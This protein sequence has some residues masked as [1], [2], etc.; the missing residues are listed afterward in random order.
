MLTLTKRNQR[1]RNP[2][3]PF[4]SSETHEV[5]LILRTVHSPQEQLWAWGPQ[6]PVPAR[7]A[8]RKPVGARPPE[9]GSGAVAGWTLLG[10]QKLRQRYIQWAQDTASV[11]A[12][13][14]T[15]T[16]LSL[17][18]THTHTHTA[19][20]TASA[21]VLGTTDVTHRHTHTLFT[22][23]HTHIQT[24]TQLRT[25]LLC[26]RSA[27]HRHHTQTH[28]H[29]SQQCTLTFRLLGEPRHVG[30]RE[31]SPPAPS[32]TLSANSAAEPEPL[33]TWLLDDVTV[34]VPGTQAHWPRGTPVGEQHRTR[35]LP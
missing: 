17:S 12:L 18:H 2:G 16:S 19:Q 21:R 30:H 7:P 13:N 23:A 15:Q 4:I 20:D 34:H 5:Q 26:E 32:P 25:Q 33:R 1:S 8:P 14:I 6:S 3:K 11:R 24:H 9:G 22:A 29:S 27:P 28:T 35:L 10:G 31:A